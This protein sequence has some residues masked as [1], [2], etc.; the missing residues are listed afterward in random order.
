[1]KISDIS[2]PAGHVI[3]SSRGYDLMR[4]LP[5]MGY[6]PAASEIIQHPDNYRVVPREMVAEYDAIEERY[7][8]EREAFLQRLAAMPS[9]HI[10]I[11]VR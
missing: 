3:V 9:I 4:M 1:M 2:I 8:I 10:E 6:E 11:S 5:D 7:K